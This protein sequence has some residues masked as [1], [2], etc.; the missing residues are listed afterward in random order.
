MTQPQPTQPKAPAT[1]KAPAKK[2]PA[3]VTNID[4]AKNREAL[5]GAKKVKEALEPEAPA[6]PAKKPAAKAA[7]KKAP[8]KTTSARVATVAKGDRTLP[9]PAKLT[10]EAKTVR[11]VDYQVAAGAR[12]TYRVHHSDDGGWYAAQKLTKNG[13]WV[14]MAGKCSTEDQAKELA[15]FNEGGATWLCYRDVVGTEF[16]KLVDAYGSK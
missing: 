10:W 2:A 13:S 14:P 3:T 12:H 6:K 11:D 7:A 1:K 4:A 15:G 16:G 8:A 5:E 9:T